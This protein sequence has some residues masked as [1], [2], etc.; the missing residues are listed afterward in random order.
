MSGYRQSSFDPNAYEQPGAPLR[1]FNRVQWTGVG[2][3]TVGA[4][5][6]LVYFAGRF[7]WI[8]P[9]MSSS[10]P[11]FALLLFG[12]VLINSRR[13]PSHLVTAEQQARNKRTLVITLAIL[14]AIFGA[15][16]AIEFSGA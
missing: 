14:T 9:L 13:G 10:T 12:V 5:A 2:L 1:P 16:L 4:V 7:G 6:D 15:V 8:E 3:A 11:A